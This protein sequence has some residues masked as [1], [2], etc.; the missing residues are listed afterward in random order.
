MQ[1]NKSIEIY[2]L[3]KIRMSIYNIYTNYVH[4]VVHMQQNAQT[5]E[6]HLKQFSRSHG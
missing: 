5:L 4:I 2:R 3:D 1:Y 6:Y